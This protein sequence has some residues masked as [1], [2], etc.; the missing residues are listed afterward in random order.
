MAVLVFG[1]LNMDLVV[2]VPRLPGPGETVQGGDLERIPGGKGANQAVAAARLGAKVRMFGRVGDDDFGRALLRE[3]R[4]ADVDTAGVRFER[5]APTGTA[6]I[7]VAP[8]G[9]NMIA[10]APG[11]NGRVSADDARGL[12]LWMDSE[13]VL[14]LQLEVPV[15]ANLAAARA[16]KLAGAKVILDPAP[17]P[18]DAP[19]EL[20]EMADV[21]TPNEAEASR[22]TGIL[23]ETQDGAEEAGRILVRR[24]GCAVIVT[25]GDRGAVIVSREGAARL[26]PFRVEAVDAVA[27]G[28][29]FNGA[30]AVGLVEGLDLL[31]AARRASAAG[32]LAASVRGAMPSLPKRDAV[33]ALLAQRSAGA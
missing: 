24:H 31:R 6:S 33:D 1:S 18:R 27:A 14:M 19:S 29:A 30:L 13:A 7:M 12:Q 15:A 26:P 5:D 21:L 25:L 16:A 4:S 2:R 17:A 20:L 8:E 10:V 28:D 23:V 32:A 9:Q 11:A 22:L 3:L